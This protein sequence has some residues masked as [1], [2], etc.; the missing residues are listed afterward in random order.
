MLE[1]INLKCSQKA[2]FYWFCSEMERAWTLELGFG[3]NFLS[4]L[5]A[6]SSSF[7]TSQPGGSQMKQ[8]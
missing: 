3:L 6:C 4:E 2:L 1:A 7:L 8:P 5:W